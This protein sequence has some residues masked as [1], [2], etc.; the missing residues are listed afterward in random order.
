VIDIYDEGGRNI[1]SGPNAGDGRRSPLKDAAM[2]PLGLSDGEK[3]DLVEFLKSLTDQAFLEDP[4]VQ[5]PFPDD[6]HFGR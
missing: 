2:R 3:A 5:N 6:V 1:E 4:K